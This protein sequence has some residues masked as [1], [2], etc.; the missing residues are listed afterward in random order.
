MSTGDEKAAVTRKRLLFAKELYLHGIEHSDLGGDLNWMLAV[1]HF[2]HSVET[3]LRAIILHNE[4]SP[5]KDNFPK[6]CRAINNHF[7]SEGKQLPYQQELEN[8]LNRLRN[9][10]QHSGVAPSSEHMETCRVYTRDF[11]IKVYKDYFDEDFERLL[12]LDWI[13]DELLKEGLFRAEKEIDEKNF[14][15]SLLLSTI[16]FT[17]AA[18]AV[19]SF[20]PDRSS[21]LDLA[22]GV[23]TQTRKKSSKIKPDP[24]EL[25]HLYERVR[26]VEYSLSL[27]ASEARAPLYY[28]AV[29]STGVR[30]KDFR[31]FG[32]FTPEIAG[33]GRYPRWTSS[34]PFENVKEADVRW[35]TNFVIDTILNWQSFGLQPQV[36]AQLRPE[37]EDILTNGDPTWKDYFEDL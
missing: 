34:V 16:A 21:G 30:L 7:K 33:S 31:K 2:H 5:E 14:K 24:P 8:I 10:V 13:E 32:L 6:M 12:R 20:L 17:W 19:T 4:I 1:H 23:V 3:V 37:A 18:S 15:K 36:P 29:L 26:A 22:L 11:L 25:A 27:L 35:V 9:L 28:A